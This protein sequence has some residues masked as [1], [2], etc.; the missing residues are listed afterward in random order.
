MPGVVNAFFWALILCA[1]ALTKLP[2]A[3]A[4]RLVLASPLASELN[5]ILRASE[6]LHKSLISQNEEHIEIGLRDVI[7][8][9]DRSKYALFLAKPHE[10]GHLLKILDA[11]RE[12]FELTQTTFGDERRERLIEAFHQLANLVRIYRLDRDFVIFFCPKDRTTWIQKGSK[13]Q[14]PFRAELRREN[15]GIKVSK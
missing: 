13:P 10:R 8:Q 2:S 5:L 6:G 9:I 1:V 15:C 4:N 3:L 12:H 11:A 7:G 14:S